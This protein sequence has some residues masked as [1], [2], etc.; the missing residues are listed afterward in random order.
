[1]SLNVL[2]TIIGFCLTLG[3]TVNA[4][5]LKSLV[6]KLHNIELTLAKLAENFKSNE[7]IINS[8][9]HDLKSLRSNLHD[10]GDTVNL[11]AWKSKIIL[12]KEHTKGNT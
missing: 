11:L 7:K 8:H 6:N 9:D 3:I 12:E 10:I 5:F 4:F 1:M 2:Y